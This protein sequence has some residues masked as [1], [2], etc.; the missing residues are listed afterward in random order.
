[1]ACSGWVSL[2][3]NVKRCDYILNILKELISRTIIAHSLDQKLQFASEHTEIN[4]YFNLKLFY[5]FSWYNW[6][7]CEWS[8]IR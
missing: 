6:E 7:G 5:T 2:K 4:Y 8:L 1:M 3:V